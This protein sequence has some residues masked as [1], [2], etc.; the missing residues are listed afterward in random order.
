M[1]QFAINRLAGLKVIQWIMPKIW[2]T[3]YE[4]HARR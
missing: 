3:A 2:Y 1:K 4:K